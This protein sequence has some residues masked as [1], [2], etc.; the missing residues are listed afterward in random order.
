MNSDSKNTLY[1]SFCGKS[2]HE[3]RKLIA[4]PTVFICD[5]CVEL[6]DDIVW[7][8]FTGEEGHVI[9]CKVGASNPEIEAIL[10]QTI[11]AAVSEEFP[12]LEIRYSFTRGGDG[13]ASILAFSVGGEG[14]PERHLQEFEDLKGKIEDLTRKLSVASQKYLSENKKRKIVEQQINDLKVEYFDFM[15]ESVKGFPERTDLKA[16][17]FLDVSGFSK[18]SEAEKDGL[19]NL[20]RGMIQPLLAERGASELNTW[21]DAIVCTFDDPETA[22]EVSSKFLRHLS[23]EQF[24]GRIGIAWGEV[25]SKYNPAIGRQDIEGKV[26]DFAARLEPLAPIGSVLVSEEFGG[27]EISNPAIELVPYKAVVKKA[28]DRFSAGEELDV[29]LLRVERN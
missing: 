11:A 3:V 9:R 5:E 2:Q 7:A 23:V 17:M 14:I 19:I 21:G 16:V 1:C 12:D 26:V 10:H 20:L 18:L 24:E 8:D 15:R 28:F 25:K 6:C 27:L 22:L 4:G 13:S 29:F